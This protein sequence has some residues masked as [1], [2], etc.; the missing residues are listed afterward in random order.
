M[1][2]GQIVLTVIM[3][4]YTLVGIFHN[5]GQ[6]KNLPEESPLGGMADTTDLKSVGFGCSGSSP[7]A[8]TI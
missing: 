1:T 3:V 6:D 4:A 8:E 7:E 2:K 5:I